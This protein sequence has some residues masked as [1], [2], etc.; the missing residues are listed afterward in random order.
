MTTL[1]SHTKASQIGVVLCLVLGLTISGISTAHASSTDTVPACKGPELIGSLTGSESGLASGTY[2]FAIMNVGRGDC[3]LVGFPSLM[4]FRGDRFYSLL[5]R[6]SYNLDVKF[7]P[8]VLSPRMSGAFVLH[9]TTGCMPGG[10]PHQAE[11]TY[12]ELALTLPHNRGLVTIP[13]LTLYVPCQ[14]SESALGWAKGFVFVT[15]SP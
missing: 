1:G 3:L 2:T 10:D 14:L 8:S 4:G 6:H 7:H 12:I 9:S 5:A 11:H 13:S 15:P